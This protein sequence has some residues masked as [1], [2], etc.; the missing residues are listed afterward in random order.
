MTALTSQ[1]WHGGWKWVQLKMEKKQ[2]KEIFSIETNSEIPATIPEKKRR[3]EKKWHFVRWIKHFEETRKTDEPLIPTS[4]VKSK[5][6]DESMISEMEAKGKPQTIA[7]IVN[8][9][10]RSWMAPKDRIQQA[11]IQIQI[12]FD[13]A[14]KFILQEYPS[15]FLAQTK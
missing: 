11:Q 6:I 12:S 4:S 15:L 2:E 3:R 5:K 10:P 14:S 9:K 13:M 1:N 8:S 7:P